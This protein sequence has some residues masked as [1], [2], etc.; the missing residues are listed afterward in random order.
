MSETGAWRDG[1]QLV[2]R[3]GAPMPARCPF[4]NAPGAPQ[5]MLRLRY[6]LPGSTLRHLLPAP[7][8]LIAKPVFEDR[9]SL[10]ASICDRHR[11]PDPVIALAAAIFVG[12]LALL[13]WRG[14]SVLA[15]TLLALGLM[16][17]LLVR[18]RTLRVVSVRPRY[19]F[20]KGADEAFLAALPVWPGE[21]DAGVER[22]F[23]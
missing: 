2:V 22:R 7:L 10:R 16:A 3:R 5:T 13:Q 17:G 14:S 15:W 23:S 21:K 19:A 20:L 1:N 9:V 8:A 18:S 11:R 12:G 6:D 4:C